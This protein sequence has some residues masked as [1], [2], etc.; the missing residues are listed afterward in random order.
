[1]QKETYREERKSQCCVELP[2]RE[3][4]SFWEKSTGSCWEVFNKTGTITSPV[5]LD[6][7]TTI[8]KA[9]LPGQPPHMP[10]PC[11]WKQPDTVCWSEVENNFFFLCCL[12]VHDINFCF[13]KL[14]II[15]AHEFFS[16]LIF[17]PVL[18]QGGVIEQLGGHLVFSQGQPT[19]VLSG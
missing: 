18:L 9:S 14:P 10:R 13:S 17:L 11:L 1:M 7:I 16:A 19:A 8:Y 12:C 5:C 6:I 2:L 3:G 15:L 4:I